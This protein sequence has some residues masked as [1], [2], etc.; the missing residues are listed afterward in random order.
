MRPTPTLASIAT[1]LVS[2]SACDGEDLSDS[3]PLHEQKDTDVVYYSESCGEPGETY[4]AGMSHSGDLSVLDFALYGDPAP[5]DKGV[6]VF[7][8]QVTDAAS[9]VGVDGATVR[10]TPFMPEH[11]HG[12]NPVDYGTAATGDAGSYESVPIDLFMSGLWELTF[13]VSSGDAVL[14]QTTYSFCLEG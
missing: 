6:N 14:D 11:G 5:P 8:V 4:T 2:L 10:I 3:G 12:T 1:M 13:I 7:T 9:D